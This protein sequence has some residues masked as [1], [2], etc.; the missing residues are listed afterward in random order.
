MTAT[1]RSKRTSRRA[2]VVHKPRGIIHPRVQE[3]GAEHFGIVAV[4]C[5]K[6]RSKWM[7]A[8]FLGKVLVE[9]TTVEHTQAGFRLAL[10]T[11]SHAVERAGLKDVLVAVERTGDYH[12]AVKRAF[13]AAG[14]E[15]R[16][17]HP[18][19]T[20]RHRLA[21][22]PGNKTDDTDLAAIHRATV[23]GFGLLEES[24]DANSRALRLLVRHRRSLVRKCSSLCCQ[25]REHLHAAM[26]GYA[27]CFDDLWEHTLALP[28]AQ[29]APSAE[30]I[31]A[32]G[33]EG[34]SALVRQLQLRMHQPTLARI[35]A[36]AE[37]AAAPSEDG[38]WHTRF[39][40][41]WEEDR[42]A[43]R[44]KIQAFEREI[45]SG[46]V[47]TPYVLLLAIPGVNVV[48]AAEFAGEM[49]PISHY[50]NGNCITGRAGLFPARYQSDEV[51]R[52]SGPLVRSRNKRLRT[53]IMQIADNLVKTNGYFQGRALLWKDQKTDARLIRVRVAKRFCRIAYAMVSTRRIG[54]HPCCRQPDYILDKLCTFHRQHHTLAE[55]LLADLQAAI[56]QLPKRS[57]AHEAQPL[58][59][60][61]ERIQASRRRGPHLLGEILPVVLAR[62]LAPQVQSKASEERASN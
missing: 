35:L 40:I 19:A 8:D 11:L 29:A 32:L 45:A 50:A 13:A 9:P 10:T 41:D 3:V 53:A 36:W 38:V 49:G 27:E 25:M 6:H 28:L 21:S 61:L 4:D 60:Q 46:L 47:R 31:Q 58:A 30:T 42:R 59:Q 48:S 1:T 5:A 17:V 15:V 16:V 7:L 54:P 52:A 37:T 33:L 14:Y 43:K 57:Y 44:Q 24:L 12:L 23:T 51:D 55:P 26:P 2:Y 39:W 62:L 20:H 56:D 18:S 34:L 22:D